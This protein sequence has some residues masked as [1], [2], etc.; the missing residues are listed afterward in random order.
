MKILSVTRSIV[1]SDGQIRTEY[2]L[3]SPVT[4]EV[5]NAISKG[6]HIYTGYQY[7][8]PTYQISKTDKITISGI[9]GSPIIVVQSQPGMSA[10]VEDYV[11][12]FLSTIP[13]SEKPDTLVELVVEYVK[14]FV[15]RIFNKYS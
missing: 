3:S 2:R 5:L 4:S 13:D 1:M 9:V 6:N 8:S 10:G 15:R 14:P 11:S 7:L 12:G